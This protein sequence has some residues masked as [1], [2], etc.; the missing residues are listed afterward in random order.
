MTEYDYEFYLAHPILVREY[1]RNLEL[2]IEVTYPRFNLINPFYDAERTE[3]KRVDDNPTVNPYDFPHEWIV[4]ED[5]K[6][7]LGAKTGLIAYLR[8]DIPTVGTVCEIMIAKQ[9]NKIVYAIVDPKWANHPWIRYFTDRRFE[10]LWDI[11]DY[12][13]TNDI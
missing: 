5:T 8:S 6:A 3:I 12:V 9:F 1:I 2:E 10:S 13:F 7:I 11:P 4:V